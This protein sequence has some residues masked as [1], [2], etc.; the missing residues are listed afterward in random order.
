MNFRIEK[1]KPEVLSVV[2]VAIWSSFLIKLVKT[3]PDLDLSLARKMTIPILLTL[4]ITVRLK[5]K[6]YLLSKEDKIKSL[7]TSAIVVML[8]VTPFIF[9][10]MYLYCFH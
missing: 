5:N 6:S 8:F 9:N 3:F 10:R 1:L 2:L 7:K 4:V